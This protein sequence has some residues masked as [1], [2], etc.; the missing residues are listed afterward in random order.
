LSELNYAFTLFASFFIEA[1]PFL[2]LG[3]ILSGS[4]LILADRYQ[5]ASKFPRNRLFA[6]AVGS[7]LGL[8]VPVGQYGNIPVARRMLLQ[9]VPFPVAIAFLLAAP[10]INPFVLLLTWKAFRDRPEIVFWRFLFAWIV[11]FVVSYL[12]S[13]Y[14]DRPP[15]ILPT[16]LLRTGSFLPAKSLQSAELS[17]SLAEDSP[18][19]LESSKKRAVALFLESVASE[20]QELGSLLILGCAIAAFVGVFVSPTLLFDWATSPARQIL[21]M[22]LLGFVGSVSAF[23]NAFSVSFLDDTILPGAAIAFL[24]VGSFVELKTLV[25]FLSTFSAKFTIYLLVLSVQ[26]IFLLTLFLDFYIS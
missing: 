18:S 4:F 1:L 2:F 19:A 8:L 23:N 10:T 7:S 15:K 11:A 6:A 26:L 20:W 24:L 9:G 3:I 17:E 5:L 13:F 14:R 16:S 21:V 25:L 12:L 22:M